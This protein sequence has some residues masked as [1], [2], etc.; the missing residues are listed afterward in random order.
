MKERTLFCQVNKAADLNNLSILEQKHLPKIEVPDEIE[1]G[2]FFQV[3]VTVGHIPHPNEN[4]HFIQWVELSLNGIY[5]ARF[6]FAPIM[7]SPQV[8]LPIQLV[9][10]GLKTKLE[11]ASRCNLHGV[12][13]S[14]IEVSAD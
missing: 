7:T 4:E 10:P 3:T 12:W 1:A 13:R 2:E 9:H 8:R 5:L 11:A 6:D 14:S